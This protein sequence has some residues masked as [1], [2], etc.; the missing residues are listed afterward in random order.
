MTWLVQPRLINE[1]FADPGLYLDVLFARRAILFD[2]GDLS[3]LSSREIM[4]VSHAFVS[5]TH[6]DHFAGFDQLL[7]LC[8]HRAGPLHLAGPAGFAARV[9]AKLAGYTWNLLDETSVD[10]VIVADEFDGRIRRRVRFAAREAFAA[11]EVEP[12]ALPEGC[13]L[14]EDQFRI[15]AV[16]LDHGTPCLGF[17]LQER[18]RVNVVREGLAALALPVGPWLNAAKAAVRRGDADTTLFAIDA[19]RSVDLA[20]LKRQALRVGP[21][22]RVAYVV[23]M[24]GHAEN[25]ARAVALATGAHQLFIEAPFLA[26]DADIAAARRHLTA[27]QAGE[28]ARRAG[29]RQVVPLHFSPRYLDRPEALADE[30]MRVFN[31]EGKSDCTG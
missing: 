17:A 28:I 4:R 16:T 6:M 3:P 23:D 5:H 14:A 24:A 9:A 12:P 22:Q 15:E 2:L 18:L 7:R 10:F 25:A 19:E 29:V 20:T 8:L 11:R 21:G 13:L 31:E 30:V 26:E 1:P 27:A